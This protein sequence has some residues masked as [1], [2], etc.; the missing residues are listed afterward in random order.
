MRIG[1]EI[2]IEQ[3]LTKILSAPGGLEKL[4]H[5]FD[6]VE[7]AVLAIGVT[8]PP[9]VTRMNLILYLKVLSCLL[10]MKIVNTIER[11]FRLAILCEKVDDNEFRVKWA[12]FIADSIDSNMVVKGNKVGEVDQQQHR[13]LVRIISIYLMNDDDDDGDDE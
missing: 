4:V 7:K 1:I 3:S 11:L 9:K 12:L 6:F 8:V 10:V 5:E 13:I 2:G